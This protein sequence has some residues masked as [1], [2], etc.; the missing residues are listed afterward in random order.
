MKA[1]TELFLYQMMWMSG[2]V[3]RPTWRG[4]HGSFEEW[5]Y[6][7]GCLRQVRELE[8]RGL[9]ETAEAADGTGRVYRLTRQGS[10]AAMGGGDPEER[11]N[12]PWDGRWRMAVFDLPEEKRGLR[13]ELR[14]IL[15][16][17]RFGC[18]QGSVWITPDPMD[19][20]REDLEKVRAGCGILAFFEGKPCGG[21]SDA[22]LVSAAWDFEKIGQRH[23]EYLAHLDEAP[24]RS[25]C[26]RELLCE[27]GKR[28]RELWLACLAV[29]PLLPAEL[30]P[31]SYVGRAASRGRL[32]VLTR[33]ARLA[34]RVMTDS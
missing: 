20:V 9:L 8:A 30:L 12:R 10:L 16:K 24:K 17:A 34:A 32:E 26:T 4:L 2:V 3:L 5:A 33:T 11:W 23:A 27:W 28:E 29:D 21:E 22:D 19:G 31:K 25:T 7:G 1:R 15:K 18:L 6:R 13:N 14:R